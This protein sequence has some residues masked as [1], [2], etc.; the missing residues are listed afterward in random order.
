MTCTCTALPPSRH[1]TGSI[2]NAEVVKPHLKYETSNK[3]YYIYYI[4]SRKRKCEI[5]HQPAITSGWIETVAA[6]IALQVNASQTPEKASA[7]R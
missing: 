7:I 3:H 2:L 4:N 1:P 5:H 6:C